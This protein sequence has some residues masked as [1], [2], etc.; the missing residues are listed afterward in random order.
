MYILAPILAVAGFALSYFLQGRGQLNVSDHQELIKKAHEDAEKMKETAR[1]QF[2][3]IKKN[4]ER[5]ESDLEEISKKSE[6]VIKNKEEIAEK[7]EN[8]NRGL[9][10]NL[11]GIHNETEKIHA[12]YSEFGAKILEKL[13]QVSGIDTKTALEQSRKEL[14]KLI[15][16]NKEGRLAAQAEE[17]KEDAPRHAKAIIQIVAQRMSTPSSVDKNS[18]MVTIKEDK[19]KGLLVGKGGSNIMYFETLLPVAIIF[20]LDPKTIHVGGVNLLRRNIAKKA[21]DKMQILSKKTGKIDHEMIKKTIEEAE[22]EVMDIC[23]RKGAE[24][25]RLMEI[26]PKK[27]DPQLVNYFGRMYF[28]TSFGQNVIWHSTEMGFL[29]RMIAEQIGAEVTVATEGAFYHDIGKA[30]DHDVGGAHDDL[31]KEILEKFNYDPRIVHAAFAHHDKVPCIAPEDFIVKA[32]DA[33][34]AVR[35][36]ARQESVTNYFERIKQLENTVA[37]FAGVKKTY[38]ISAGREVRVYV[39]N[40]KISDDKMEGLAENIAGKISEELSFPGI[41]KVNLIRYTKSTDYARENN[42]KPSR[43]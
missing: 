23:D 2:E 43:Q 42:K 18:T 17:V 4:L 31:S 27:V 9:E 24:H 38:A 28:R 8:R 41:I 14:E 40:D 32:V 12:Q 11:K 30:V 10:G 19:F 20:N 29:A 25:L 7:R 5:E 6:E 37:S 15:T 39:D 22:K 3:R 34:S 16:E 36:G 35:P 33:I 21:I 1:E 13:S 26:D